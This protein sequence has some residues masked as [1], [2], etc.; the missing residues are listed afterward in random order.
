MVRKNPNLKTCKKDNY[1]KTNYFKKSR[2]IRKSKDYSR[3]LIR[4]YL[5]INHKV[6]KRSHGSRS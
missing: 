4:K 5:N 1:F 2:K 6:S 3:V